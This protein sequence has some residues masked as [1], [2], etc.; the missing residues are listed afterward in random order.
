MGV[1]KAR[2]IGTVSHLVMCTNLLEND[3]HLSMQTV[4]CHSWEIFNGKL[5]TMTQLL[6]LFSDSGIRGF[7]IFGLN[8]F[9]KVFCCTTFFSIFSISLYWFNFG[10]TCKQKHKL[11]RTAFMFVITE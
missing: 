4:I 1:C 2:P 7:T 9:G 6:P 3:V 10:K 5:F 11:K 8:T